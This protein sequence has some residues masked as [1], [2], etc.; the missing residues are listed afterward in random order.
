MAVRQKR[1]LDLNAVK[2]M[3]DSVMDW[4]RYQN[5]GGDL[6][7][8]ESSPITG[9]YDWRSYLQEEAEIAQK[10]E[11]ASKPRRKSAPEPRTTA[12]APSVFYA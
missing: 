2:A 6:D 3:A 5:L 9:T 4:A 8:V 10:R 11:S 12:A 7:N 1:D